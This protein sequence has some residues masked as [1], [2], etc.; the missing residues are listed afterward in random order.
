MIIGGKRIW[1]LG[2]SPIPTTGGKQNFRFGIPKPKHV[3]PGILVVTHH[4]WVSGDIITPRP[5]MTQNAPSTSDLPFRWLMGVTWSNRFWEGMVAE[6]SFWGLRIRLPKGRAENVRTVFTR[7]FCVQSHVLNGSTSSFFKRYRDWVDTS[8][9]VAFLWTCL[10]T[11]GWRTQHKGLYV[12]TTRW[13]VACCRVG[14]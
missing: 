8:T 5:S 1:Y 9:V 3:Y 13:A 12:E 2:W 4:L 14:L 11:W 10:Q 6:I 7:E